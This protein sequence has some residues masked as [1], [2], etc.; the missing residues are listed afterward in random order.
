MSCCYKEVLSDVN[1]LISFSKSSSLLTSSFKSS[2]YKKWLI[3]LLVLSTGY[4]QST[5]VSSFFNGMCAMQKSKGEKEPPH[6]EFYSSYLNGLGLHYLLFSFKWS[7][8]FHFSTDNLQFYC[9]HPQFL[10]TFLPRYMEHSQMLPGNQSRLYLN[11][12]P[13]LTLLIQ[14]C[15]Y[16]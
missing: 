1:I 12:F 5:L 6:L 13:C 15:S 2:I 4:P 8:V 10:L 3:F 7:F 16:Q 9:L 14:W 11:S